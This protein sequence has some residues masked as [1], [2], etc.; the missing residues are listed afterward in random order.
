MEVKVTTKPA[1][2]VL[3]IEGRGPADKG[4]EWI[5]PLWK[6]ARNRID[7]VRE[8][9][10]GGGWGLM[11]AIDEP[12]ARWKEEGKYLA[13][14]EVRPETQVP[15]GWRMWN[16][17]ETAFATI[18]C[19]ARTYADAWEFFHS[20]FLQNGDYTP[21]GAVHEYYPP[22]FS[23]PEEDAFCLYF[24]VRRKEPAA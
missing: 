7:E 11:S 15:T 19:T 21:A 4:P 8:H 22:E 10:I 18:A 2:A 1:F 12:F 14:W 9:I 20:Q 6:E 17:P 3:G 24:T 23:D 13:G 16:V 5:R